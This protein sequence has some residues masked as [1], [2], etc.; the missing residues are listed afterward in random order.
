MPSPREMTFPNELWTSSALYR[1]H[2]RPIRSTIRAM[3]K[4][5]TTIICLLMRLRDYNSFF[6]SKYFGKMTYTRANKMNKLPI[7]LMCVFIFFLSV[8]DFNIQRPLKR[9]PL[10]SI[11]QTNISHHHTFLLPHYHT[12]ILPYYHTTTLS[13]YH[14]GLL[15]YYPI[16]LLSYYL[17]T[18]LPS[19]ILLL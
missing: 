19:S 17:I 1:R 6:Q 4:V 13:Y 7:I 2:I 11:Y 9:L 15:S 18:I 10:L 12:T 14:T 3:K 8:S 16:I 5:C